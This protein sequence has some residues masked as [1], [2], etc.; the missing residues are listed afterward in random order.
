MP[1][2]AGVEPAAQLALLRASQPGH[3]DRVVGP[4]LDQC[5]GLQDGVVQVGGDVGP[6]GLPDAPGLLLAQV[7][8]EAG[9][10]GGGQQTHPGH[11]EQDRPAH[12][13]QLG[14]A[15]ALDAERHEPGDRQA[16]AED[17]PPQ[18]LPTVG[19]LLG[20]EPVAPGRVQLRPD[21]DRAGREHQHRQGDVQAQVHPE[22]LDQ[23]GDPE[24]HHEAA[25]GHEQRPRL[26]P[27]AP[28]RPGLRTVFLRLHRRPQE[29]VHQRAGPAHH[30]QDDD[31]D[32]QRE[33]V[34]AEVVSQPT[35][36][37]RQHP[38]L[39]R[40][41]Q[42]RP[43]PAG[44]GT[45]RAPGGLRTGH[46]AILSHFGWPTPGSRGALR[47]RSG[48]TLIA[49]TPVRGRRW[50]HD[51]DTTRRTVWRAAGPAGLGQLLHGVAQDRHAAL[52]RQ[53]D[54]RRVLRARR[55]AGD[56]PHR[57]A[58]PL[59]G[60]QPRHGDRCPGL[61]GG[62]AAD[63]RHQREHPHR[64]GA[65]RRGGGLG[66]PARR[67][68]ARRVRIVRLVGHRLVDGWLLDGGLAGTAGAGR[69]VAVVR[70]D[71]SRAARVLQQPRHAG[72]TPSG[73]SCCGRNSRGRSRPAA[74]F[75]PA[76][77]GLAAP[78]TALHRVVPGVR[79]LGHAGPVGERPGERPRGCTGECP[80]EHPAL[81]RLGPGVRERRLR[82]H[83]R[84]RRDG[85]DPGLAVG[86]PGGHRPAGLHRS[87]GLHR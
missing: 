78:C 23:G 17:E 69:L 31:T 27:P 87:A 53:L 19:A 44:S 79:V 24:Q 8:P 50:S 82:E 39:A 29:G 57:G 77:V 76:R 13:A 81:R 85:L 30:R 84:L 7:A 2:R 59:R 38:A 5:Q 4:P 63:S 41:P 35:A 48:S 42:R 28:A 64:A 58:R 49:R 16:E 34:E 65:A 74:G 80:R 11:G 62:L 32:P 20:Q 18:R 47:V 12:V 9:D 67:R 55:A 52:R 46:H 73:W 40:A 37:S 3:L 45:L 54:R 68:A 26:D 86:W 43:L 83:R 6:L 22:P 36:Y 33:R 10:I 51:T 21:E 60:A 14:Q 1:D 72:G 70:V 75:R 71:P 61:P 15:P 25:T 66:G 56:R